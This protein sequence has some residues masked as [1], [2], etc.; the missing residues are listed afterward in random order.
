M[1][2]NAEIEVTVVDFLKQMPKEKGGLVC[3]CFAIV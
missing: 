1:S 3:W 2:Q